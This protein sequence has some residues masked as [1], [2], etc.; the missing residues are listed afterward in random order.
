M[1]IML[2]PYHIRQS[3]FLTGMPKT[4]RQ[5]D[6]N[7]D[8]GGANTSAGDATYLQPHL[9][10]T[11]LAPGRKRAQVRVTQMD[12][13]FPS[14]S[15]SE[16]P[17]YLKKS[18]GGRG[19]IRE[20]TKICAPAPPV[21]FRIA[22]RASQA[23]DTPSRLLRHPVA[24][25]VTHPLVCV[26]LLFGINKTA[27]I[28]RYLMI[29]TAQLPQQ[30]QASAIQVV[31]QN[32]RVYVKA[33]RRGRVGVSCRTDRGGRCHLQRCA[34]LGLLHLSQ[35]S[36]YS[37]ARSAGRGLLEERVNET[38]PRISQRRERHWQPP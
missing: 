22:Y 1:I 24:T 16:R 11:H 34:G 2:W 36:A 13:K 20:N 5:G 38:M 14:F 27:S 33:S 31:L 26:T 23:G 30:L 15:F 8:M 21:P 6:T 28:G 9:C 37:R 32:E 4:R 35:G 17:T 25:C 12:A 3:G 7:Q 19:K 29:T 10:V 18:K